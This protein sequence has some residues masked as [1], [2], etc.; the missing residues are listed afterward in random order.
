MKTSLSANHPAVDRAA[1][2]LRIISKTPMYSTITDEFEKEFK[3]KVITDQG[4]VLPNRVDFQTDENLMMF[5]LK[6]S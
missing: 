3:C 5:L 6:W 1:N 2:W 4:M